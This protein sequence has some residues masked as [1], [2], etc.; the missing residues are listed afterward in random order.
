MTG[1]EGKKHFTSPVSITVKFKNELL[2]VKLTFDPAFCMIG[3]SANIRKNLRSFRRLLS[4]L[5]FK[6]AASQTRL[7]HSFAI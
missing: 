7:I 6:P 1:N 2:I 4:S 5:V 3:L